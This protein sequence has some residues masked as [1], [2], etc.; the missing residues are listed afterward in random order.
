[1]S[2]R[3]QLAAKRLLDVA[4]EEL[5]DGEDSQA[6]TDAIRFLHA[7]SFG[8]REA[9]REVVREIVEEEERCRHRQS[10]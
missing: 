4:M 6:R 5:D 7:L 9:A 10:R 3:E 1:L 2:R 8:R